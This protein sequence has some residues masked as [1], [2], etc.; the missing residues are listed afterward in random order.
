MVSNE[1][2]TDLFKQFSDKV[3]CI[4]LNSCYSEEQASVISDYISY[5]VGM[6][7]SIPD[8]TALEYAVGF[9]KALGSGKDYSYAH[10]TGLTN[11]KLNGLTGSEIPLFLGKKKHT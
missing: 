1:A 7:N 5:V 3:K 10:T 11:V 8:N 9:Y 2:L 6:Q 4:V